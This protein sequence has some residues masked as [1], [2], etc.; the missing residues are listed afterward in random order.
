L[1]KGSE[2]LVRL[3]IL[4]TGR[5]DRAPASETKLFSNASPAP[6]V[7]LVEDN[8]DAAL[9]LR[10]LL[11]H[12]GYVVQAVHDGP[13]A[14]AAAPEFHP[15][16]VLLDIGLPGMDG[17]EVARRMRLQA[18]DERQILVALTGYGREEDYRRSFEAGFDYH[19]T[20]PI[21]VD[22]LQVMLAEMEAR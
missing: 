11:K 12:L 3:P 6:R 4:T 1:G 5:H 19:L 7:L 10:L 8:P 13:A 17:Y 21:H 20:K 15:Q 18:N 16:I 22:D 14:L 9:G 2:F